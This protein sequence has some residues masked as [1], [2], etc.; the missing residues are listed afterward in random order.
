MNSPTHIIDPEREVIIILLNAN[1]PIAQMDENPFTKP[2]SDISSPLCDKS[3]IPSVTEVSQFPL[4]ERKLTAK[5]KKALKRKKKMRQSGTILAALES[6]S[7]AAAPTLSSPFV[8]GYPAEDAP[9]EDAPAEDAP[10][11]D[12]SAEAPVAEDNLAE[13][14]TAE[15]PAVEEA[16]SEESFAEVSV[17]SCFRIQVSAKHLMFA[18]PV[19]KKIL[20]G[21]WKESI[22]YFQKGSVEITAETWDIDALMIVLQAMHCQHYLI[23]EILTLDMLAKVAVIADYYECKNALHPLKEKWIQKLEEKVPTTVSR[24]LVLWLWIAWFFRLHSQFKLST[25][26]AMSQSNSWIDSLG[27][28]IPNNVIDTMNDSREKAIES[29]IVLLHDTRDAFLDGPRGCSFECRSI[30]YGSL[31]KHMQSSNLLLPKPEAPFQ[32]LNH[33]HLV[34]KA[35][36]FTSPVW[37]DSASTYSSYGSGY[38]HICGDNSFASVFAILKDSFEGLELNRFT[39]L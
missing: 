29:L 36:S 5:E 32:G 8:E 22:T 14:P 13:E 6:T 26:I 1:I 30:M 9:A 38:R 3:Q 39:G 2:D 27:L 17:Q 33:E 28:P 24:D 18:S 23:S 35:M 11:E 16:I 7:P 31:T 25:S 12:V 37:F 10:A 20:T 4:K 19:F 34:Q 15:E 21:G